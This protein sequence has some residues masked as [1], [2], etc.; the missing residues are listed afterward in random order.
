VPK[1]AG[2]PA[3]EAALRQARR[4]VPQ[5]AVMADAVKRRKGDAWEEQQ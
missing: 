3:C 5:T 2:R 1:T 4:P